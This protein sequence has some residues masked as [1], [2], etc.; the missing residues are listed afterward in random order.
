MPTS[1]GGSISKVGGGGG[2]GGAKTNEQIF[3]TYNQGRQW[4]SEK[5]RKR[6]GASFPHFLSSVFFSSELI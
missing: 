5:F 3:F 2:G 1:D 4:R 6:G